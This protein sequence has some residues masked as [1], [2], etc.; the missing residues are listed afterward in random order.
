MNIE[1]AILVMFHSANTHPAITATL[2]DFLVRM[3]PSYGE[4]LVEHVTQ[5]IRNAVKDILDKGV[6]R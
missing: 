6:I 4:G 2:L 5:G 1:P 3:V